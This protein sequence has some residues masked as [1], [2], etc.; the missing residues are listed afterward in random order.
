MLFV[1]LFFFLEEYCSV[2][3]SPV[4]TDFMSVLPDLEIELSIFCQICYVIH[5][6]LELLYLLFDNE[7]ADIDFEMS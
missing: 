1:S 6:F 2:I 3:T 7:L 4:S 5:D